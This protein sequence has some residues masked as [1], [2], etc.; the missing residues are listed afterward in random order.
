LETAF[1][2]DQPSL[3]NEAE[4]AISALP[5]DPEVLLLAALA[6]LVV[7]RPERAQAFL[8]R[9]VKRFVAGKPVTLLSALA[10]A[11]QGQFA[12][13]WHLLESEDLTDDAAAARWFIGAPFMFGWLGK[14]LRDIRSRRPRAHAAPR[15]TLPSR[16]HPPPKALP[17]TRVSK[18]LPAYQPI[19]PL[20]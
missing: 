11:Q 10:L 12:R 18:P 1:A 17:P 7:R 9:F 6:A 8:K 16:P 13:A 19:D 15:A 20:A 4:A 3:L 14:T 5:T 2:E